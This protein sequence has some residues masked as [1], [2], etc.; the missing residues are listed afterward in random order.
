MK[1]ARILVVVIGIAPLV[2]AIGGI[3]TPPA[4]V[5]PITNINVA[6][7]ARVKQELAAQP[8]ANIDTTLEARTK[9]LGASQS[10]PTPV[11]VVKEAIPTDTPAPTDNPV[12]TTPP[13][14]T[15][16]TS[17]QYPTSIPIPYRHQHLDHLQSMRVDL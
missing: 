12:S 14:V 1:L 2:A 11:V 5:T 4:E 13:T 7:E 9:E 6:L 10:T 8:T 15:T 3:T 16:H 17:T